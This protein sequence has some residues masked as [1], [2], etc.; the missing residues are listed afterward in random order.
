MLYPYS[1]I[2]CNPKNVRTSDI[3]ILSADPETVMT[4]ERRKT[5][6]TVYSVVLFIGIQEKTTFIWS[7]PDQSLSGWGEE[8]VCR[9]VHGDILH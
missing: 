5:Q 2:L 9:G 4:S 1:R 7:K 3:Q 6:K 8:S